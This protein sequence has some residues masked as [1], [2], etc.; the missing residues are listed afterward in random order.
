MMVA[1]LLFIGVLVLLARRKAGVRVRKSGSVRECVERSGA[2]IATYRCMTTMVIMTAIIM[3]KSKL[4]LAP[5]FGSLQ[6][7]VSRKGSLLWVVRFSLGLK[8]RRLLLRKF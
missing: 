6:I 4:F 8:Y 1:G 2:G 5:P 7:K 3:R